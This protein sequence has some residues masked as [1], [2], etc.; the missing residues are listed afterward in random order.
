MWTVT[1]IA[2]DRSL[3]ECDFAGTPAMAARRARALFARFYG[4]EVSYHIVSIVLQEPPKP[5]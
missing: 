4:P 3:V 5:R 2:S 1:A